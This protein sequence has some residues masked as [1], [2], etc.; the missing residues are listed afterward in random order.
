MNARWAWWA[1]LLLLGL[2][3]CES[4]GDRAWREQRERRLQ[5]IQISLAKAKQH[6]SKGDHPNACS[7]FKDAS[8][9]GMTEQ[10]DPQGYAMMQ[11]SCK[12]AHEQ[13][14]RMSADRLLKEVDASVAK[15][16]YIEACQRVEVLFKTTEVLQ[17]ALTVRSG[18][19][20]W[21]ADLCAKSDRQIKRNEAQALV[22]TALGHAQ[23]RRVI[24]ACGDFEKAIKL[25]AQ[26]LAPGSKNKRTMDDACK[27]AKVLVDRMGKL[28]K[29]AETDF[30]S[31][32]YKAA[33]SAAT[34]ASRIYET[35]KLIE[36]RDQICSEEFRRAFMKAISPDCKRM[37]VAQNACATV[38]GTWFQYPA[39]M[40]IKFGD[41]YNS[42]LED[43]CRKAAQI[44][45]TESNRVLAPW[46]P[47]LQLFQG[48]GK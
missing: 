10:S 24:S 20:A 38:A 36:S 2:A 13:A 5:N 21:R 14:V 4:A 27:E 23:A 46:M 37:E 22:N 12:L 47:L 42:R 11:T 9:Y 6:A 43:D 29:Q 39:C 16:D 1:V 45:A 26:L 15:A 8:F 3:G 32:N 35:P 34:Q 19:N 48:L 30:K 33:C 7:D 18:L 40:K 28:V 25:D 17:H 31:G 41:A 44:V